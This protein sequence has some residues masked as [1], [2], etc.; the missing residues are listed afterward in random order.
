M[1]LL[2]LFATMPLLLDA[3]VKNLRSRSLAEET[4]PKDGAV[5]SCSAC[6]FH[7]YR[8][9]PQNWEAFVAELKRMF[10]PLDR[11][12][13]AWEKLARAKQRERDSVTSYTSYMRSIFF[14]LP[15][16]H[17]T[18]QH[19]CNSANHEGWAVTCCGCQACAERAVY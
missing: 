4:P 2:L 8:E 19:K 14:A 10:L 18:E 9:R 16:T 1:A 13:L 11:A 7:C 3:H 12:R 15:S 5:L 17:I 6:K